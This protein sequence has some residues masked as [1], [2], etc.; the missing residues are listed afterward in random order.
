MKGT[1]MLDWI[2]KLFGNRF[3]TGTE[4]VN[5]VVTQFTTITDQLSEGIALIT[6]DIE[7]NQDIIAG[8]KGQNSRLGTT[9]V[10]ALKLNRSIAELLGD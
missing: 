8:L 9:K 7:C 6:K 5:D 1:K 3:K 2:K 10:K 4:I